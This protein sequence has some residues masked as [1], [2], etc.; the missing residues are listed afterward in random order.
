[1]EKYQKGIERM[2]IIGIVCEYNPFHNGHQ[3]LIDSVKK[4]GDTVVCVMSGN[5][6]QR[7]EPAVFTKEDRVKSALMCGADIVLELPF[8]YATASAEYFAE[9]AVRILSSFGCD[10]IAFGTE[11]DD[12]ILLKEAA[13]LLLSDELDAKTKEKLETGISYP[14][15]RQLAFDE[16]G[17]KIDLSQPNIILAVEYL[18]AIEKNGFNIEPVAVKRVGAGYNELKADGKYVSAAYI[19][20]AMKNGK[21]I[22][23]F[24]PDSAMQCYINAIE[25]GSYLDL[26]KYELAFLSVLRQKTEKD[27]SNTAYITENLD[28]RIKASINE[29]CTISE[30]YSLA[31]TKRFTHSRIRRAFLA[32]CFDIFQEDIDITVPYVRL[33]GFN[34]NASQILGKCAKNCVL[35]FVASYS[36]IKN[37]NSESADRVFEFENKS[38]AFYNLILS[39]PAKCSTEMTFM[40]VKMK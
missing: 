18:K 17:I 25:K 14:A 24:I 27:I 8:L 3:Y 34:E 12:I 30:L 35:P 16:Y 22:M 1:M 36:D 23:R 11:N 31:K 40:P 20:E 10:K 38:T 13:S 26:E 9:N 32:I 39:N 29:A 6:V 21:D 15:A 28:S 7:S 4:D 37:L 19:R 2:S 33:L 5:F